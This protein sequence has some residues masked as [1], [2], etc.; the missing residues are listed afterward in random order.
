MIKKKIIF[1]MGPTGAGKSAVAISLAKKLNT[2]IISCDS[3]QVYR[4]LDII[5]SK[6]TLAQ[7]KIVKHHLLSVINPESE[8]NVAKYRKQAVSICSKLDHQGKIPLFVGGTGLYYSIIVD[9]LFPDVPQDSKVRAKLYKLLAAKGSPFLH[10]RLA[11]VDYV[12]SLKIHAHD[13]K[14]I[15][16]ALEVFIITGKPISYLQGQRLGLGPVYDV[17]VFGL[18]INRQALYLKIDQRVDKMFKLG[19]ITEVKKLL[20]RKL[21]R[22]ASYAIGI[23]ELQGYFNRKYSLDEA[24]RLIKRNSRHYAKR[25]LTWFRHDKRIQWIKIEDGEKPAAIADRIIKKI[26][27]A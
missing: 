15:I 3:M 7:R 18:N 22:T 27:L 21:S 6:V 19:L 8:Y 16:R 23:P 1:L 9:G 13:A 4:G 11:N 26:S 12:S 20:K 2:E 25:Q 17:R 10:Q 5:T 24:K 14:R